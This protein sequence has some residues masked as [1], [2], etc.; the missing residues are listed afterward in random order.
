[1]GKLSF[2]GIGVS[3]LKKSSDFYQKILDLEEKGTYENVNVDL[4]DSN[5]FIDEIVLGTKDSEENLL[6]LMN[7]PNEKR[8]YDGLNIKIVFAVDDANLTMDLIRNNGGIVDREALP[9]YTIEGGLVGLA[10]DFDNNVIEIIQ[11]PKEV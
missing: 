8:S 6:V 4:N 5:F 1:M 9:H 2:T 7:W 11:W 3:N 10:R